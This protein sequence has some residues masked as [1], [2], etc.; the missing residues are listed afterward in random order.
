MQKRNKVQKCIETKRNNESNS[1]Q[2][3]NVCT[4]EMLT[5]IPGTFSL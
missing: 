2:I 5:D 1:V 4:V 3:R